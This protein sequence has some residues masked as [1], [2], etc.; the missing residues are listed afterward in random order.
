M[1]PEVPLAQQGVWVAGP[2]QPRLRRAEVSARKP[3][4]EAA[5][6]ERAPAKQ[7]PDRGKT[8]MVAITHQSAMND[9]D[10]EFEI[11]VLQDERGRA[12]GAFERETR[13]GFVWSGRRRESDLPEI[14]C[15]VN[16]S[17]A[18][19]VGISLGA[20]LTDDANFDLAIGF[21]RAENQFLL[22]NE[23]VTR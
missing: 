21:E 22:R 13:D 4:F 3:R 2:A 9:A 16:K 23:F 6:W 5:E 7:P 12:T 15:F 8:T 20:D 17:D 1:A 14:E 10:I 11:S 19:G 18:I